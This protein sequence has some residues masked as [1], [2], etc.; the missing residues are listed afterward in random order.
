MLRRAGGGASLR[1]V[2][3]ALSHSPEEF[4]I[5]IGSELYRWN[6]RGLGRRELKGHEPFCFVTPRQTQLESAGGTCGDT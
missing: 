4:G 6:L 2:L 1:V 3:M 5:S